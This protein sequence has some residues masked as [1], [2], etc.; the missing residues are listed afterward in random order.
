MRGKSEGL[1]RSP[2]LQTRRAGLG[3]AR[4][5]HSPAPPVGFCE[6]LGRAKGGARRSGVPGRR[7]DVPADGWRCRVDS[8]RATRP[9][10]CHGWYRRPPAV[11][12]KDD[13]RA[14]AQVWP[15]AKQ[16]HADPGQGPEDIWHSWHPSLARSRCGVGCASGQIA[17]WSLI[18]VQCIIGALFSDCISWFLPRQRLPRACRGQASALPR[19]LV[20]GAP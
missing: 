3:R 10:I 15:S 1:A 18:A 17:S 16:G 8:L 4:R 11:W 19:G 5:Q 2:W 14:A 9:S 13:G 6:R 20:G 7:G 12:Y